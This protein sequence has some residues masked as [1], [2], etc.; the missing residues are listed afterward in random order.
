MDLIIAGT[1]TNITTTA[2]MTKHMNKSFPIIASLTRSKLIRDNFMTVKIKV[3]H[4]PIPQSYTNQLQAVVI[5][6]DNLT[7][8]TL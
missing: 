1:E 4:N 6:I 5:K 3:F 8:L 7:H 2:T